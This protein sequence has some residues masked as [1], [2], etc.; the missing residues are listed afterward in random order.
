LRKKIFFGRI[1]NV[2]IKLVSVEYFPYRKKKTQKMPKNQ[3]RI[4]K[5]EKRMIFS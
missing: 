2:T 4:K 5:N 1:R 3:K